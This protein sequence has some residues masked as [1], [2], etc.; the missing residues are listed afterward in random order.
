MV[1]TIIEPDGICHD[2]L[3]VECLFPPS[4]DKLS[5]KVDFKAP[6]VDYFKG[7]IVL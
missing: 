7:F 1:N 6:K 5:L 4:G 2:G 3:E